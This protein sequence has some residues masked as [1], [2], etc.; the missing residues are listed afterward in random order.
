MVDAATLEALEPPQGERHILQA[1]EEL[2]VEISFSKQSLTKIKLQA[3][4][5]ELYG[6]ELALRKVYT[7][8][9]GGGYKLA[10]FTWHGCVIDLDGDIEMVYISDETSCNVAY[11]NTHAQ[12]EALRDEAVVGA[13]QQTQQ[14]QQ[15]QQQPTQTDGPRVLIVGPSE[16]GKSSLAKIL[17]AYAVKLGRTPLWV[18]LDPDD[19]ALSVPGTLG[20]C[21]IQRETITVANYASTGVPIQA[22]PLVL[23]HGSTHIQ[24]DL[25]Q[26]QVSALGRKINARWSSN[27]NSNNSNNSNEWERA[28]GLVVNTNGWIQDVEGYPLLLHTIKALQISVILVM[29]HDRLYSMLRKI[30]HGPKVIKVPRSGGV[31]SRDATFM[32]YCRSRNM[33]RYFYG[34]SVEGTGVVGGGGS[35]GSGT[36]HAAPPQPHRVPQL[37]PFL[38]QIPFD[39]LVIYKFTSISLSASLLPVA[40][41]QTTEPVQLVE[42]KI[43]A[44]LSHSIVAVCHPHAV[45]AYEAS[46]RASDLYEAGVAGFCTVERVVVESDMVHL[47]SPCAGALPSHVLLLG[48]VTWME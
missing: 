40:A 20:V 41:A 19:N 38:L 7:L 11:V 2:R 39:K 33:K 28:S 16:S 14:Q 24:P 10:L 44:M 25:F 21:P 8:E 4:S 36:A 46:G 35:G 48:D 42:T 3:G 17:I 31:V 15:Q 34:D 47:L 26:A 27:T 45:M 12:L 30:E 18:D 9:G 32:R 5:A 23:W 6:M 29:G 1:E 22:T 37:T 43:S 13:Q